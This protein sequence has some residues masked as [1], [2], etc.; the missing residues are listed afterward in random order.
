MHLIYIDDS[1]DEKLS[2]Y[3]ALALPADQWRTAFAD[4]KQYRARRTLVQ[5]R[6]SEVRSNEGLRAVNK[7]NQSHLA[8]MGES[9][10]FDLR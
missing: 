8:G 1:A 6:F 4:M 2:V 7:P 5:C 3:S 9:W 10:R